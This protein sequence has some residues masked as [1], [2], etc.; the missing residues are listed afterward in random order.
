[1]CKFI[2]TFIFSSLAIII[3]TGAATAAPVVR[4][5]GGPN[6]AAVQAAVDQFRADLAGANNGNGSS[7]VGGRREINWDGAGDAVSSPNNLAFNAFQGRGA[8]FN[9]VA[10]FN[11][12]NPFILS[13]RLGNPAGAAVRYGDIDPSYTN[14]F[15]AFSGERLFVARG[16]NVIEVRFVIPGTQTPATV[17]GFGAIFTDVDDNVNTFMEFYDIAGKQLAEAQPVPANNGLSF[18]GVSFNGSERVAKVLIR[19]GN[20]PLAPGSV[21]GVNGVDVVA[22]DDFIYGEPRAATFHNS[23]FDG[24]GVSDAVIFRPSSATWFINNS[25]GSTVNIVTFGADG[26]IPVNGDFD[27]DKRADIAIYR[28]SAGEWWIQKSSNGTTLALRF[29]QIGDKPVVG[30]YDRDGITDIAF[31]RPSTGNYFVLRSRDNFTSF[32][33]FQFGANGDIPVGAAIVP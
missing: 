28:P 25:G 33:G 10:G 18:L 7:F 9:S 14:T 2:S 27:G 16:S 8:I 5:A 29:G 3:L 24:D 1:M 22:T 6:A 12:D 30:D 17:S 11:G 31:W 23:D 20:S 19:L 21:D 13:A 15:Q 32:F 4:N 26:D